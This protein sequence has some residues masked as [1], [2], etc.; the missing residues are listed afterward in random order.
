MQI[1]ASLSALTVNQYTQPF[2]IEYPVYDDA[3]EFPSDNALPCDNIDEHPHVDYTMDYYTAVQSAYNYIADYGDDEHTDKT[4]TGFLDT[5]RNYL[6]TLIV[7][8]VTVVVVFISKLKR[9]T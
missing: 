2:N 1:G 9:R 5:V 7:T 6:S 8:L 4:S 3:V